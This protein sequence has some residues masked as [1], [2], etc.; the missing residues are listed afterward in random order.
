MVV[1]SHQLVKGVCDV[2]PMVR[3]Q[4]DERVACCRFVG[5]MRVAGTLQQRN[6]R[7]ADVLWLG[8]IH[9]GERAVAGMPLALHPLYQKRVP[10]RPGTR[11]CGVVL[12]PDVVEASQARF[13]AN[14]YD[15]AV[16]IEQ[17]SRL[18]PEHSGLKRETV[19]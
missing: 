4:F 17:L 18:Y 1:G 19:A 16:R 6:L 10:V 9:V 3:H 14:P 11:L 15:R 13:E 8:Q 5:P 2:D 12:H 7:R